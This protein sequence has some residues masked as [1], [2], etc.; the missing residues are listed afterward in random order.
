MTKTSKNTRERLIETVTDLIWKSSYCSV[1]VDDICKTAGVQKGSFYHYFPSKIDLAVASM[2]QTYE[3]FRPIMDDIFSK[4]NSPITRFK[5]YAE[6]AYAMQKDIAKEHGMVC[7]CP[8]VSLAAEMAPQD[9]K[10]QKTT[11]AIIDYH[12]E[13]YKDALR[14]MVT[15]GSLPKDTDITAKADTINTFVMGQMMM[16]RI[17]NSLLPLEQ[18]LGSG[19]FCLIGAQDIEAEK[20]K[21]D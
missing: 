17:R 15:Q 13:Y 7:G 18:N 1:S 20:I 12:Q 2:E 11:N 16:A 9:E 6:L 4:D 8:F 19:L 14:D 3:N 5:K 10:I 21:N